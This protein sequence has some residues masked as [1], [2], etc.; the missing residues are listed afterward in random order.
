MEKSKW[1]ILKKKT[2]ILTENWVSNTS[3]WSEEPQIKQETILQY[4]HIPHEQKGDWTVSQ[5]L[6]FSAH[7]LLA[8]TCFNLHDCFLLINFLANK[9]MDFTLAFKIY[10]SLHCAHVHLQLSLPNLVICSLN[11]LGGLGLRLC[12]HTVAEHQELKNGSAALGLLLL[13]YPGSFY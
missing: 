1:V 4:G 10:V 5:S 6:S 11:K 9:I 12:F 7:S 3:I 13:L 8:L 2:W